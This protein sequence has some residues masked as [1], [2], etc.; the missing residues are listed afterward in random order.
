LGGGQE[1][2]GDPAWNRL[3]ANA[4]GRVAEAAEFGVELFGWNT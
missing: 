2:Y 3:E 1:H 4:L